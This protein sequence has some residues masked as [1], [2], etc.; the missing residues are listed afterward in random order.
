MNTG[1]LVLASMVRPVPVWLIVPELVN[2][3]VPVPTVT[4]AVLPEVVSVAPLCG[5]GS[6]LTID[7]AVVLDVPLFTVKLAA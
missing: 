6:P 7:C 5:T 2:D 4:A 3:V 1:V